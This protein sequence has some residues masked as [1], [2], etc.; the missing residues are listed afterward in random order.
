MVYVIGAPLTLLLMLARHRHQLN[1]PNA[2][3][4]SAAIKARQE[5]AELMDD[6]ISKFAIL[7]RPTFWYWE[8]YNMVRS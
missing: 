7:Y 2:E 3:N 1:P 8:I 5:D 6:P 4:E